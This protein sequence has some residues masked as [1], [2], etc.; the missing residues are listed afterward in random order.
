MARQKT[1]IE[2]PVRIRTKELRGGRKSVYLDCYK[3]GRRSYEFLRL[4]LL[5]KTAPHSKETNMRVMAAA[6]AIQ[7]QRLIE[8]Q[9]T[10]AHVEVIRQK[11]KRLVEM[12]E[13]YSNE[14]RRNKS[15]GS[16][17]NVQSLR[18][19]LV[20][21]R[22]SQVRMDDVDKNFILGFIDYLRFTHKTSAGKHL[23]PGTVQSYSNIFRAVLN[24]AV[25]R[26]IIAENPFRYVPGSKKAKGT[27]S[28]RAYLTLDELQEMIRAGCPR[29]DVK[30]AF[31]FS[32][33]CGMRISDIRALRWRDISEDGGQWRATI[34]MQKTASALY[35]PLN[36]NAVEC[37]PS[38]SHYKYI[39]QHNPPDSLIFGNLPSLVT[40]E[41]SLRRWTENAGIAKHI[42]FHSARHT[43]ATLML[44]LGVDLYTTSRLLGHTKISTTQIY[45]QVV[46]KK[47]DEAVGLIDKVLKTEVL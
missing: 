1:K 21:F 35:L 5:P 30:R 12:V 45:A 4:Y 27:E 37:M 10:E 17:R 13:M 16:A 14:L 3:E 33:F 39:V 25:R 11:E 29:D 31:L 24:M 2:G 28:M 43:F 8:L 7:L 34:K 46:N 36:R 38:F 42:T 19:A 15:E 6:R 18:Q 44:T 40:I 32:C 9:E 26:E 47:K 41:K 23:M 20:A 22:G